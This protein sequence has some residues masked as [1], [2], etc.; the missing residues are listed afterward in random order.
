MIQKTHKQEFIKHLAKLGLKKGQ[1]IVLHANLATF[2]VPSKTFPNFVIKSILKKIGKTGSLIM[3][4]YNLN[5]DPSV[6]YNKK[7]IYNVRAISN[8]YKE[9]FKYKKLKISNSYIHRHFGIG[10]EAIFLETGKDYLSIGKNSDFEEFFNRDFS[11][12]LLGCEP[13][14][15]ATY[16]HHLEALKKVPYRKWILLERKIKGKKFKVKINYFARKN[17]KYAENFNEVFKNKMF[18]NKLK[19]IRNKYGYSYFIKFRNLHKIGI[20]ILEENIHG[21]VKK[22]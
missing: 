14:E 9:Y 16:L 19:K 12:I 5:L 21:F 2:G 17:S 1:K 22:K 3:P 6:I 7:K 13:A 4:M 18:K 8:I 11:L 20:K 15:G 10:N